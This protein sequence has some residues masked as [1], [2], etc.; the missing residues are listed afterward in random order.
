VVQIATP[1]IA[2]K[3]LTS[4]LSAHGHV[5]SVSVSAFPAF[6]LFWDDADSVD[7]RMS[8]YHSTPSKLG[9]YLGEAGGIGSLHVSVGTLRSG[10]LT[11]HDATLSA[12]GNVVTAGAQVSESDLRAALPGLLQSI[13]PVASANGELTLRGT[14]NVP[15]FGRVSADFIA[16]TKNGKIVVS[17]DL[18][19]LN[20][21]AITVWSQPSVRVTSIAGAPTATGL[22]VSATATL[23]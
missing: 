7:V 14:V 20:S 17:P 19:L 21:F 2:A 16:R 11:V 6:E 18:P 9:S 8:T 1:L 23:R 15:L 10:L 4:R 3:I 22:S 5:I 12:H 13:V